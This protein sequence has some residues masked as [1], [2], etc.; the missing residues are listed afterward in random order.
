[1]AGSCIGG[2]LGVDVKNAI[3]VIVVGMA[4]G[5]VAV[6]HRWL[7]TH[8]AGPV[9]MKTGHGRAVQHERRH[10]DEHDARNETTEVG[11]HSSQESVLRRAGFNEVSA[12]G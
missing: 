9:R 7:A 10:R 12:L 2:L 1:M 4:V 8:R 6:A 5:R 11:P 3:P